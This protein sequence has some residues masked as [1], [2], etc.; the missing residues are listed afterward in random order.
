MTDCDTVELTISIP[1]HVHD[2][3]V[4]ITKAQNANLNN[5]I[6]RLLSAGMD[7]VKKQYPDLMPN[8]D[9]NKADPDYENHPN[10]KY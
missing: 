1:A 8:V 4:D 6:A 9:F 7:T 10:N 5:N 2:R 3:L